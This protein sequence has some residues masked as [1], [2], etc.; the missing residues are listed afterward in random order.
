MLPKKIMVVTVVWG[1]WHINQFLRLNLPTLMANGNFPNL[2]NA[3]QIEYLIYTKKEDL[4]KLTKSKLIEQLSSIAN[5]KYIFLEDSSLSDPIRVHHTCWNL[6]IKQA[7]DENAY[8]LLMPPDVAWS[9]NSF[10]YVASQLQSGKTAI[11]M[12]YLRVED[13]SFMREFSRFSHALNPDSVELS[14]NELV[15]IALKCLHPLMAAYLR[16]SNFFPRHPEMMLWAVS[17]EGLL[18]RLLARE[19]FI[20]NPKQFS[21]NSSNLVASVDSIDKLVVAKDSDELFA[22]SLATLNQEFDWYFLPL[23]A[24]PFAI[25]KWWRDYDSRIADFLSAT[26]IRWHICPTTKEKWIGVE[27]SADLFLR[28]AAL[29]REASYLIE[30][31]DELGCSISSDIMKYAL[32]RGLLSRVIRG[33]SGGVVFLPMNSAFHKHMNQTET[34]NLKNQDQSA[35]LIMMA[36]YYEN[37]GDDQI[38]QPLNQNETV[39]LLKSLEIKQIKVQGD[40]IFVGEQ[41]ARIISG[42]TRVGHQI[43]FIIDRLLIA[44]Q[45]D[46]NFI[47]NR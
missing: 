16:N 19:L 13:K 37:N 36:H 18:C 46:L 31:S 39:E 12:T 10:T 8:I 17:G 45:P 2:S 15:E 7:G 24:D 38:R 11:F 21:L 41:K 47:L 23:Q 43:V 25:G 3:F 1:D 35:K 33:R 26:K 20:F 6:A 32:A 28:K 14:G 5:V 30:A 42:P 4:Y 27:A 9:K 34:N 29:I 22:V 44:D 40:V